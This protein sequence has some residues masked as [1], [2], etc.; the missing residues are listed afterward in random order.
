MA[1]V[2]GV[3]R[4]ARVIG[5]PGY[6]LRIGAHMTAPLCHGTAGGCNPHDPYA[7]HTDDCP[8]MQVRITPPG[9][10]PCTCRG[11]IGAGH[12]PDCA[13]P[14]PAKR[15]MGQCSEEC[16]SSRHASLRIDGGGH[17]ATCPALYPLQRQPGDEKDALTRLTALLRDVPEDP[18]SA[19]VAAA[20]D[21]ISE[22]RGEQK[23]TANAARA[24]A[25][26]AA[27]AKTL[28]TTLTSHQ[29]EVRQQALK[30]GREQGH[31][32]A[33]QWMR[34][35]HGQPTVSDTMADA[36]DALMEAS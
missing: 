31:M 9:K 35:N 23:Q 6:C 36:L 18:G 20:L 10:A 32:D 28:V 29:S 14:R 4:C 33:L 26:E 3:R 15:A 27:S 22:A 34:Q 13:R 11:L 8:T 2:L 5:Y 1:D 19:R 25:K 21:L 17:I 30:E 7:I 24:Y 16:L 12:L